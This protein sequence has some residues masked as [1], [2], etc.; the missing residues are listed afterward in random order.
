MN[1]I[2]EWSPEEYSTDEGWIKWRPED[3]N[4][5]RR[6][7]QNDALQHQEIVELKRENQELTEYRNAS[8]VNWGKIVTDLNALKAEN[9]DLKVQLFIQKYSLRD[10]RIEVP[11]IER[12]DDYIETL[13]AALERIAHDPKIASKI[14]RRSEER[15]R[16]L[17]MWNQSEIA[18]QH[19]IKHRE[20]SC[21][22]YKEA[23]Q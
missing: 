3:E 14:R 16:G 8:N 11:M 15:L 9:A 1:E 20:Q 13:A 22:C 4:W 7:Q 6:M 23:T 21:D 12:K 10:G 17:A 5:V 18:V 2:K 19:N